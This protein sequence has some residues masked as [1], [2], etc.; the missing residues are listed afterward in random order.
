MKENAVKI[1]LFA[2]KILNLHF[3]FQ[4]EKTNT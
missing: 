2:V 1:L 4:Y 3:N